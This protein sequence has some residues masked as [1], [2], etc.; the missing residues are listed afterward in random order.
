V[1][2]GA[3]MIRVVI[4]VQAPAQVAT[5]N[6]P[7]WAMS[8]VHLSLALSQFIRAINIEGVPLG[9]DELPLNPNN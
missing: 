3:Q 2:I 4:T 7:A 5:E 1:L 6:L 9:L 8:N